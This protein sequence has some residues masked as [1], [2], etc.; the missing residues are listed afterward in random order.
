ML[1][2]VISCERVASLLKV[3]SL[4]IDSYVVEAFAGSELPHPKKLIVKEL[5]DKIYKF[6]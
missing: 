3:L 5:L 4:Y 2:L 6:N 1:W